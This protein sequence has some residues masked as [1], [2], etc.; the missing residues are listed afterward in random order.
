ME[1]T[2]KDQNFIN[3]MLKMVIQNNILLRTQNQL[4]ASRLPALAD[5]EEINRDFLSSAFE[6]EK[7]SVLNSLYEQYGDF[8]INNFL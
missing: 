4:L 1:I 5:N 8:D 6:E 7:E 3:A 2:L